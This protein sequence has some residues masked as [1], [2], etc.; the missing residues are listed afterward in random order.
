MTKVWAPNLPD[1][2]ASPC[3]LYSAEDSR[4][5]SSE[6]CPDCDDDDADCPACDD[7]DDDGVEQV[8]LYRGRSVEIW[9]W[10]D[11]ITQT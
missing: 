4:G 5:A 7:D 9:S 3:C 2:E 8:G 10:T 6:V 1:E 11:N